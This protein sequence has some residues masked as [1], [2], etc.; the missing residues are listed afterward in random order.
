MHNFIFLSPVNISINEFYYI[1]D[2]FS[3]L[4]LKSTCIWDGYRVSYIM[5]YYA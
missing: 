1:A 5:I 2:A 4:M 3:T